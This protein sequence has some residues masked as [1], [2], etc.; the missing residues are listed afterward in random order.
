MRIIYIYLFIMS[1]DHL[2]YP[3]ADVCYLDPGNIEMC[4]VCVCDFKSAL[5]PLHGR[6]GLTLEWWPTE[7]CCAQKGVELSCF[8][9]ER[10]WV[11]HSRAQTLHKTYRL[12]QG[13][14]S[15]S[16]QR[17]WLMSKTHLMESLIS[18]FLYIGTGVFEALGRVP[19]HKRRDHLPRKLR[20]EWLEQ[21]RWQSSW[22]MHYQ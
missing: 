10:R 6:K 11:W 22:K 16:N 3:D 9:T 5:A 12:N 4:G 7:H 19:M 18:S 21:A 13:H 17:T 1:I 8:R 2:G 14:L 20:K 15:T